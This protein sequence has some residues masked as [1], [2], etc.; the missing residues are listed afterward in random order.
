MLHDGAMRVGDFDV[1]FSREGRDS[2]EKNRNDSE[3]TA[4]DIL[5]FTRKGL[6]YGSRRYP[7]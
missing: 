7:G 2:E 5:L 6:M 3:E 4:H 1:K